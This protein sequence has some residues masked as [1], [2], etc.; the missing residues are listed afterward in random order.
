[1]PNIVPDTIGRK[2]LE[3]ADPR[4]ADEWNLSHAPAAMR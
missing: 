1:M 2:I 3:T 4:A